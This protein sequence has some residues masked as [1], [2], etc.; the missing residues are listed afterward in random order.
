MKQLAKEARDLSK[1]NSKSYVTIV[2]AISIVRYRLKEKTLMVN[3]KI[4]K[5]DFS[6]EIT[7]TIT[8]WRTDHFVG[9]KIN[10]DNTRTYVKCKI[11]LM[12]D[13]LQAIF[14]NFPAIL[15]SLQNIRDHPFDS[16]LYTE[17]I[18]KLAKAAI[19]SPRSI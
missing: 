4:C 1:N 17:N 2:D 16:H 8:R 9:M 10:V 12:K 19:N 6:R 15:A 5:I 11:V 18:M 14:F 7:K 13:S 3:Q